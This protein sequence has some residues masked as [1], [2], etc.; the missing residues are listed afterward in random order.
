MGPEARPQ[1]L[2][3][4][5]VGEGASKGRMRGA[6]PEA[7]DAGNPLIRPSATFS[8]EGRREECSRL[9]EGLSML[10]PYS[11]GWVQTQPT[12]LWTERKSRLPDLQGVTR[13]WPSRWLRS[14]DGGTLQVVRRPMV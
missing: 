9:V 5:L 3:S 6:R 10:R 11:V 2:P 12:R 7:R 4:P 1:S 14:R 13:E 8:H